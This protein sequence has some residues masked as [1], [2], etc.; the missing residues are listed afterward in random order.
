MS[1]YLY[2]INCFTYWFIRICK[3]NHFLTLPA[4]I[5]LHYVLICSTNFPAFIWPR[6]SESEGINPLLVPWMRFRPVNQWIYLAGVRARPSHGSKVSKKAFHLEFRAHSS[7]PFYRNNIHD[8]KKKS[9]GA[10]TYA[11]RVEESYVGDLFWE[12]CSP[13]C[14]LL[15]VDCLYNVENKIKWVK[16]RIEITLKKK[17]LHILFLLIVSP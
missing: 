8:N 2:S 6:L 11:S 14:W 3:K 16:I 12:E 10:I 1:C 17:K 7:F 5:A 13:V 15:T 9:V 4:T